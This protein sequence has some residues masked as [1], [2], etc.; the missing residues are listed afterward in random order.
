MQI[1][2]VHRWLAELQFG[3]TRDERRHWFFAQIRHNV[4]K[5]NSS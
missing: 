5:T 4:A 3:I 1:L 2:G